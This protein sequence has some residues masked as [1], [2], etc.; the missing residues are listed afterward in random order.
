M[1]L[2]E[3]DR[4]KAVLLTSGIQR[5]NNALYQVI[6]QLIDFLRQSFDTI[7]V[8]SASSGGGGSV[9]PVPS[10][11]LEIGKPFHESFHERE[12]HYLIS[13]PQVPAPLPLV[14]LGQMP[15][16]IYHEREEYYL[17]GSGGNGSP[18]P[19]GPAGENGLPGPPGFDGE[20]SVVESL[21]TGMNFTPFPKWEP[22]TPVLTASVTDP[23]IGNAVVVG[24]YMRVGNFVFFMAS[25]DF[26]STTTYGS[27]FWRISTPTPVV[28][29]AIGSVGGVGRARDNSPVGHYVLAPRLASATAVAL[30]PDGATGGVNPTTPFTWAQ[31]DELTLSGFYPEA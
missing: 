9:T 29:A 4:L 17:I 16:E 21:I 12:E 8:I 28:D 27:G 26:G 20:I 1:S 24:R 2:P 15:H 10:K 22:Y 7:S 11:L 13:Q 25:F 5:S 23:T 19:A 30:S 3:L 31:N 6:N 14:N 18:G